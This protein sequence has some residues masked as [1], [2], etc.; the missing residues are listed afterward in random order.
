M[1]R[2][3]ALAVVVALAGCGGSGGGGPRGGAAGL[4]GPLPAGA[5]IAAEDTSAPRADDF[6]LTL[7]DGTGV[8]AS[9]LWATRP[10]V[11]DFLASWCDRCAARQK[12]LNDLAR[13][14]DGLVAFLGVA[15]HD[16]AGDLRGYLGSHDVPYAA[17]IDGNGSVWRA[18]AVDEPP[19]IV[20]VGKGGRLLRGWTVDV[21]E[22]T[23][24]R[25]LSKL[26][27]GR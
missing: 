26:A 27:P 17:G 14:Y 22:A 4:P 9:R 20:V 11:V 25:E 6:G 5:T 8:R 18:Y 1:R 16:R 21:P 23:L 19:V 13:R 3:A 12:E 2:A 7:L 15:A 24:D 10:V